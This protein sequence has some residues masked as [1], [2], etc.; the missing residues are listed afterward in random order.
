MR[1]KCTKTY[2][3]IKL[4]IFRVFFINSKEHSLGSH[5]QRAWG[6]HAWSNQV[7]QSRE[8]HVTR[9]ISA[10]VPLLN[11]HFSDFFFV[12]GIGVLS[13]GG[14]DFGEVEMLRGR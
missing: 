14:G 6:D 2:L 10:Q 12:Q 5:G 11:D 13:F 3:R 9:N 8:H 1:S 4:L 7:T